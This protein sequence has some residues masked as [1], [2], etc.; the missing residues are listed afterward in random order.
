MA[1]PTRILMYSQDS[2]GLGHLRRVT[3]LAN[4]LVSERPDLSVLLVVDSPVAPFFVINLVMGLTP[5]RA[6]TFWWVSQ[7]G[8]LP[9]T[10]VYIYAGSRV[11][12]LETLARDGVGSV[13][14]WQL[15][16]AFVLL[17][18]FPLAVKKLLDWARRR[19]GSRPA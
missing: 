2:Y 3:T 16:L 8:M 13:L 11:P 19:S 7:L 9:G 18:V 15:I 6:R 4:T 1:K 17:G 5:I 14:S 12:S 10:C